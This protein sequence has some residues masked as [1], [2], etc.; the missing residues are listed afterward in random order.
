[1]QNSIKTTTIIFFL[2]STTIFSQEIIIPKNIIH[3]LNNK[4]TIHLFENQKR[5]EIN[6]NKSSLSKEIKYYNKDYNL[7]SYKPIIINNEFY[8]VSNIGGLVLKLKNDSIKRIDKSFNH[9]MQ[10]ESSIFTYNNEIYRYGGYGFFSARD[11]II[12]YDF[13]TNE[14]ESV[15]IKH[16]IAPTGRFSNFHSIN[17]DEFIILGGTTVD[18]KKRENRI[19][20]DD[21]WTFSFEELRWKFIQSSKYFELYDSFAFMYE[22]K[23]VS[24]N[25]N[26]MQVFDIKSNKLETFDVNTTF[27]KN[28][29]R[30]KVHFFNN[31]LHFI[32]TRNNNQKV[33]V[34]RNESEFF[35][36]KKREIYL[37]NKTEF[38]SVFI[39]ILIIVLILFSITKFKRYY[40]SIFI[41][42]DKIKYRRNFVLISKYEFIVLK[43]FL[44]NNNI[45]ENNIIQDLIN[46]DQYDRSH[47]IRRK[48]NLIEKLDSKFKYLFNNSSLK[49]IKTKPSDFDKRYKIYYINLKNSK[50]ILKS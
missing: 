37:G 7:K 33:M 44:K 4:A 28:N 25:K 15:E 3:S 5:Y 8:F 24:R 12:R 36:P 26:E 48:N 6:L 18:L 43:E 14:W 39:I 23:I 30:F 29:K 9:K 27:L 34:S 2:I 31:K 20:L 45:L 42:N 1:M 38:L 10:V 22:D 50:I 19:L 32:V 35:G 41:Y 17:D 47:N 13:D 16:Q 40:N 49:F 21:S 11:F 46:Q